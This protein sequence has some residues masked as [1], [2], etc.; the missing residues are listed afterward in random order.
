MD[1]VMIGKDELYTLN[2]ILRWSLLGS[3]LFSFAAM[4]WVCTHTCPTREQVVQPPV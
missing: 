4:G 2:A 1:V 3:V